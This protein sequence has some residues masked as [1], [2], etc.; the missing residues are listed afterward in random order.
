M[1]WEFVIET[2][3]AMRRLLEAEGLDS[4]PKTT[5][6][7][8]LHV[9]APLAKRMAHAAHAYAK[10]LV[11]RLATAA[12]GR[13]VTVADPAG[14]AGRIFITC[15]MAAARRPSAPIRR[16]HGKGSDRGAPSGGGRSRTACGPTPIRCSGRSAR[17]RSR[18]VQGAV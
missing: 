12:I 10:R 5:G 3:L 11:Q 16:A 4:W 2:T 7:K 17:R 8:D 9:M 1:P 18:F 14:R 15:A 6:G 13:Y